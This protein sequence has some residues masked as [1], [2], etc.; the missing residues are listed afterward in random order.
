MAL[1][2]SA[3]TA[4]TPSDAAA[5]EAG[6]EKWLRRPHLDPRRWPG[7]RNGDAARTTTIRVELL[8]PGPALRQGTINHEHVEAMLL[9]RESWPPILVRR[10]DNA[11]VDGHYRYLAARRLGLLEVE[12]I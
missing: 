12:C 9:A 11:I 2:H 4:V 10:G 8:K 5:P 1:V 7:G 6:A 3:S